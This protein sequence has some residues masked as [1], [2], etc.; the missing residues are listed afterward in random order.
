[1]T[2]TYRFGIIGCGKIAKRHAVAISEIENARLVAVSDKIKERAVE[3][4]KKYGSDIEVYEDYLELLNRENVDVI[5]ICTPNFLH[6]KMGIDAAKRKKHIIMEK[7]IATE[8]NDA[9]SLINTAKANS[10][11]LTV[12][13]QVRFEYPLDLLKKAVQEGRFGKLSASTLSLRWN[14]NQE[15]FN[16][17]PWIGDLEKGGGIL[18]NQLV[19]YIDL[20]LW[21]LGPVKSVFAYT[22]TRHNIKAED[23]VAA[24]LKFDSGVLGVI[25]GSLNV[26]KESL[27]CSFSVLG[28]KGTAILGG[29][30]ANKI[31]KWSF[32]DGLDSEEEIISQQ[33]SR[34]APTEFGTGHN[35]VI[36]NMI[37]SIENNKE[38]YIT[39]ESSLDSL[40]LALAIFKSVSENRE[41]TLKGD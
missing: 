17:L 21:V 7:P 38:P 41:I 1:M 20:L 35:A 14:R 37:Y 29:S 28:D 40:N 16:D 39:P 36:K 23:Q 12:M 33:D 34:P 9:R 24:V 3:F 10:V 18:L 2:D 4:A 13:Y 22:A 19:N 32:G 8:L 25:E 30:H 31:K 5:S 26:F 15:Y 11:K 27:D 6:A